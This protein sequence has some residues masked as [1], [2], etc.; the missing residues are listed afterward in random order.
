MDNIGLNL[1]CIQAHYGYENIANNLEANLKAYYDW[2]LLSIG[3]W[4]DVDIPQSG[5]YGADFSQ[6]RMVTDPNYTDGQVWEGAKKDWVWETGVNYVDITGGIRNPQTVGIPQVNGVPNTGYY[7][8]YPLG[9]I[10]F[11]TAV[12]TSATVK[13]EHAYRSVQV[14]KAS[15]SPWWRELQQNS[16]RIDSSQFLTSQS[17]HWSIFGEYRIQT[18][19]VVIESI[20]R[21]RSRGVSLGSDKLWA[22][23][24]VQFN[25]LAESAQ[26]RNNLMDIFNLQS[27]KSLRLFDIN[28]LSYPLDYRG[29]LTGVGVYPN[30]LNNSIYLLGPMRMVDS[31]INDIKEV[32]P[33]LFSASVRTTLETIV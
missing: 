32:H 24:D 31:V 6:L 25:I 23:R 11:N 7:V 17:G 33:K 1:K 14:Y 16:R 22:M 30:F 21:G 28:T 20:P 18:P 4:V 10:I 2:G 29:M 15:D 12:S 26:E 19:A 13:V 9:Q 8:N 3:A 27:D 5:L